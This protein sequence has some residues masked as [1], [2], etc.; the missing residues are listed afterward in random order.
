MISPDQKPAVGI[1]PRQ[2]PLLAEIGLGESALPE[3]VSA[4]AFAGAEPTPQ[5]VRC[6]PMISR[7]PV[8]WRAEDNWLAGVRQAMDRARETAWT[9]LGGVGNRGWEYAAWAAARRGLSLIMLVPPTRVSLFLS[10]VSE[11]IRRLDLNSIRTTFMM[12]VAGRHPSAP[13]YLRDELAFLWAHRHLPIVL[14]PGGFWDSRLRES[15]RVVTG[16]QAPYPRRALPLTKPP[17]TAVSPEVVNADEWLIHWTRGSYG[18]WPGETD[19]DYFK[20]ITEATVGNPRDGFATLG[21]ILRTGILRGSAKIIRGGHP[22][23]SFSCL[24][25]TKAAERAHW[26]PALKRLNWEPYG[27]GVRRRVLESL[28]ARPA[29]YGDRSVYERLAPADRPFFQFRGRGRQ[30]WTGEGEWRLP[31]DLD[32]TSLPTG[33][34]CVIAPTGYECNRLAAEYNLPA[35]SIYP[36]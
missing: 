5:A 4:V 17:D 9:V 1:Y 34:V 2:N 11:T 23:I 27:I 28:G 7:L 3:Q 8:V 30:D 19:A 15:D 26:R 18:P 10:I 25:L 12:P 31:G 36:S 14:R 20:S 29:I 32:L 21:F 13:R 16:F 22:V 6:L 24:P 33:S 35:Y